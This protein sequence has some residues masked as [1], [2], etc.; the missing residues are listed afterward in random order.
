MSKQVAILVRGEREVVA[1]LQ[2][3]A[4]SLLALLESWPER[5]KL[6]TI[7]AAANTTEA[8]RRLLVELTLTQSEHSE[9]AE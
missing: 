8:L 5:G 4:H 3:G 2:V 1:D 9:R 7:T 6:G